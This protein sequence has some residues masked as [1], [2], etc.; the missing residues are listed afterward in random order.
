MV[1]DAV[2]GKVIDKIKIGDGCDGVVFDEST[3]NI[4]T[5]NGEGTLSVIHEENANKTPSVRLSIHIINKF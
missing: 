4:Y 5:S 2:T 1:L 3:K